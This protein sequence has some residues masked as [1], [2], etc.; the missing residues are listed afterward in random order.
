MAACHLTP[1]ANEGSDP[2]TTTASSERS[3]PFTLAFQEAGPPGVRTVEGVIPFASYDVAIGRCLGSGVANAPIAAG[4]LGVRRERPVAS[5]IRPPRKRFPP[6]PPGGAGK[7]PEIQRR[8]CVSGP[9]EGGLEVFSG[10][11]A[12]AVL[13]IPAGQAR[14]SGQS[15]GERNLRGKVRQDRTA[16]VASEYGHRDRITLA[17][18]SGCRA[19][20]NRDASVFALGLRGLTPSKPRSASHESL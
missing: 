18:G 1:A 4:G 2:I 10:T 8:A 13:L 9:A 6:G 11:T 17:S 7:S 3:D 19:A 14:G 20:R 16:Q 5:A 12:S 15:P